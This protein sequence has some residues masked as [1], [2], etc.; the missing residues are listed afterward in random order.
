[1]GQYH[2]GREAEIPNE[3]IQPRSFTLVARSLLYLV[4]SSEAAKRLIARLFR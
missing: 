2:S 4:N 1:M 3:M